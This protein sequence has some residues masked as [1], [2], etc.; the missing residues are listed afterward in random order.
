MISLRRAVFLH[1]KIFARSIS[2][3]LGRIIIVV[4]IGHRLS[5]DDEGDGRESTRDGTEARVALTYPII[6]CSAF[7]AY[8]MFPL[9]IRAFF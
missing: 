2:R 4:M 6:T 1:I 8:F 7:V 3:D 5:H 9:D